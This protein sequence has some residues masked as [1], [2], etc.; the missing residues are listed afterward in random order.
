MKYLLIGG[1]YLS[2]ADKLEWSK[3][4]GSTEI[5]ELGEI[6]LH[7]SQSWFLKFLD[8]ALDVGFQPDYLEKKGKESFARFMEPNNHIAAALSQLK[9]AYEWLDKL[10]Q[11]ELREKWVA[12]DC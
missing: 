7:E 8:V 5:K 1:V 2:G 4:G 6:P 10:K 3:G 11:V 12:G 9:Q